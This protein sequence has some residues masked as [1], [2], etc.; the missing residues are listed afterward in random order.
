MSEHVSETSKC[1]ARLAPYCKGNGLDLG[2]GGDLIVPDAIGVDMP[3]PYT[4]VGDRPVHLKG[5]ARMLTWFVDESIDYIFSSH[6]L[7]DFANTEEVLT[8]WLRVLKP[9]G[10]LI[11]FLPVEQVYRKHCAATGQHYNES[12]AVPDMSLDYIRGIYNKIGVTEEVHGTPLVDAYSFEIVVRK[13]KSL[14]RSAAFG[15]TYHAK[16]RELEWII[17]EI[18]KS[19]TFKIGERIAGVAK[20]LGLVKKG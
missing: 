7:E 15:G 3:R 2:C 12:H 9:G 20:A 18:K 11:L 1:R 4:S 13:V 19:P 6:L 10:V 16:I 8:E 17:D 14:P 5:D